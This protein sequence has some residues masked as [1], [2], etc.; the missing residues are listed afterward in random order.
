MQIDLLV[1]YGRNVTMPCCVPQRYA[2]RSTG[3]LFWDTDF[4]DFENCTSRSSPSWC[5]AR[6]GGQPASRATSL[7]SKIPAGHRDWRG[8]HREA[9][10]DMPSDADVRRSGCGREVL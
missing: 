3:R 10:Q 9:G 5:V 4:Y 8:H 7:P 2:E 1:A 6:V